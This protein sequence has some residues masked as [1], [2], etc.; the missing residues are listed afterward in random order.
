MHHEHAFL[1]N[2][3]LDHV[4]KNGERVEP[5]ASEITM[6]V[7]MNHIGVLIYRKL[8]AMHRAI[9]IQQHQRFFQLREQHH[10]PNR[11]LCRRHQQAVVAARV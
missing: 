2:D 3:A 10:A 6:P 11:R 8:I 4:D 9:V 7:W 5:K 1:D